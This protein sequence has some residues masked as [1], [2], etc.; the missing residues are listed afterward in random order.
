MIILN[1]RSVTPRTI[2]SILSTGSSST[3]VSTRPATSSLRTTDGIWDWSH[4]Q[5]GSLSERSIFRVVPAG[6]SRAG[7]PIG[8]SS[9]A[10]ASA[11]APSR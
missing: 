6:S 10:L 5:T 8:R 11:R 3:F 7:R 2:S 4:C 1:S 9:A